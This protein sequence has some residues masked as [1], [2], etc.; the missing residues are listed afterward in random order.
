MEFSVT[1]ARPPLQGHGKNRRAHQILTIPYITIFGLVHS[2][3]PLGGFLLLAKVNKWSGGGRVGKRSHIRIVACTVPRGNAHV[4]LLISNSMPPQPRECPWPPSAARVG[5]VSGK[6][7]FF[8]FSSTSWAE[9][10]NRSKP[11]G[12]LTSCVGIAWRACHVIRGKK[13]DHVLTQIILRVHQTNH[14]ICN[15]S[16]LQISAVAGAIGPITN[17]RLGK[18]QYLP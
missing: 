15:S 6:G 12:L 7:M 11:T 4:Q 16:R 9:R 13:L 8:A 1:P 17:T 14:T 18:L 5:R 2:V 10:V 3:A